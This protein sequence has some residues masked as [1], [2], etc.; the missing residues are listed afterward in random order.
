MIRAAVDA[1]G[2]AAG[3]KIIAVTVLT[4][5]GPS[6]LTDVGQAGP[7]SEQVLRLGRLARANGADGVVA[8]PHE[9][10][11]LRS[12]LGPDATLVVP[13]V[14]PGWAGADDQKRI[15]TPSDAVNAGADFIVIGR[16]ITR[17]ADPADAAR[18]IAV[19][20]ADGIDA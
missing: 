10:G 7:I 17:A 1:R 6:D 15:M 12:A 5:L 9:V 13:G 16:P 3:P 11:A 8:S 4:S 19:E 20:I 14:R 18:R 2:G